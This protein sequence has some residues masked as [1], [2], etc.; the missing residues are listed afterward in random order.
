MKFIDD[1]LKRLKE[2]IALDESEED[3]IHLC[4][5]KQLKTLI[6]RLEA[7]EAYIFN[8]QTNGFNDLDT[9]S[10]EKIWHESKGESI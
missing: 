1:D 6:A 2:A 9:S 3:Q 4:D 10:A 5:I 8:I 7:A